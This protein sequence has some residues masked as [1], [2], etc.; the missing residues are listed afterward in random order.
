MNIKRKVIISIIVTLITLLVNFLTLINSVKAASIRE[1]SQIEL[2][3]RG[4]CEQ[5]LKYKGVIVKTNY[6]EYTYNGKNYP[7][8]C[9]DKTL[10]GITS[11]L[12]YSVGT[13]Q[14]IEDLGLWR[15][16]INGYPYK[17]LSELGV[18]TEEEAFTATKQAIYCYLFE[19]QPSDYE[20]IGE[21]GQRTLNAL[22]SIVEN[23]QNST[24]N[25]GEISIKINPESD[26]WLEDENNPE[27]V[28]K[29]YSLKSATSN[30][31]YEVKFA[32]EIPNG[33]KITK[34]DGTEAKVFSAQE[35]FKVM[36][37]KESLTEDGKIN[38][39][40]NTEVK[41]KPVIYGASPNSSWQNYALT[42]YM[43]EDAETTFED[44][45]KKPEEPE[46]PE[47]PV[48]TQDDRPEKEVKILPVTGM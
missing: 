2:H 32:G 1:I 29:T 39:N 48:V 44:T 15:T 23:G 25:Q 36:L 20:A 35:S 12:I 17:S 33:S 10:Q 37:L 38:L 47:K 3:S 11:E 46:K 13:N 18:E 14:K 21:E 24:E 26:E 6:V 43:Y 45:Y 8:Y 30:L 4:I 19:N 22:Y 41:T 42:G 40:I 34:I 28:F 27:Y 9:L 16:V 7:A 5:L 31:E